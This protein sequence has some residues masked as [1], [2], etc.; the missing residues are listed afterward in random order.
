MKSPMKREN[1]SSTN[2][3]FLIPRDY[4]TTLSQLC[5]IQLPSVEWQDDDELV[6]M[7]TKSA[8]LDTVLIVFAG[9]EENHTNPRRPELAIFQSRIGQSLFSLFDVLRN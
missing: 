4:M 1:Y 2:F 5:S 6:M 3:W 8:Y 9:N 7:K